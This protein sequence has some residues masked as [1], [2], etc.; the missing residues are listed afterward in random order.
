MA[1]PLPQVKSG[2]GLGPRLT[3]D[4]S[5]YTNVS[6]PTSPGHAGSMHRALGL[7]FS[8]HFTHSHLTSLHCCWSECPLTSSCKCKAENK[9]GTPM[10]RVASVSFLVWVSLA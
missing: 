6:C 4:P 10:H 5:L 3:T 2:A 1:G 8:E 9:R 7:A